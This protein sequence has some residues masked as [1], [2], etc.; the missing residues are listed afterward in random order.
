MHLIGITMLRNGT[1]N[2]DDLVRDPLDFRFDLARPPRIAPDTLRVLMHFTEA[3]L[4]Q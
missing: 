3:L 1:D 2:D 4:A